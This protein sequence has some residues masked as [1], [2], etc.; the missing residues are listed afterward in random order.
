[1]RVKGKKNQST[2][3]MCKGIEL[4]ETGQEGCRAEVELIKGGW[5]CVSLS[6]GFSR[7]ASSS[8][9]SS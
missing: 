8:T 2:C 6:H 9:D 7:S 1:M 3:L 5:W 4:A